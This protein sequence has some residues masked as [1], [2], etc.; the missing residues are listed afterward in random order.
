MR[1]HYRY[2]ANYIQNL[3]KMKTTNL[4]TKIEHR[5]LSQF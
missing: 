5:E 1:R 2:I 3:Q 4:P